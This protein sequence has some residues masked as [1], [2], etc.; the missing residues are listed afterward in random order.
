MI[1]PLVIACISL[2]L[3]LT[4]FL[5]LTIERNTLTIRLNYRIIK[6]KKVKH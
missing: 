1:K 5:L 6:W 4:V 3:V 2:I